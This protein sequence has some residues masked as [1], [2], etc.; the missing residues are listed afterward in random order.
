MQEEVKA[1]GSWNIRILTDL[2]FCH[3]SVEAMNI[4]T[5]YILKLAHRSVRLL[6][7]QL[8]VELIRNEETSL[9]FQL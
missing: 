4:R 6:Q 1:K 9:P 5:I 2:V 8:D 7:V 3:L